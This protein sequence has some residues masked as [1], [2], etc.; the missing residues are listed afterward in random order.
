MV[1]NI[2]TRSSPPR[3]IESP[4]HELFLTAAIGDNDRP[5]ALQILQGY[6]AMSPTTVLRRRLY[7]AGPLTH[8]RGIDSAFI[9]AQGPKVP[10]WRALNEQ[11]IRQ[12]YMVTLLYDINRDQFPKPEASAEEKP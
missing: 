4:M 11:L 7:W 12:A 3:G 2:L 8:N 6:C 10:S 9:M 5:K 1:V